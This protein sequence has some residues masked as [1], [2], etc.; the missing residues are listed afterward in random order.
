MSWARR[1]TKKLDLM[2][3]REHSDTNLL[4]LSIL[5]ISPLMQRLSHVK[6]VHGDRNLAYDVM[7]PEAVKIK[8]LEHQSLSSEFSIWDLGYGM[9]NQLDLVREFK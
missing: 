3:R 8:H 1:R 9:R 5:Q 7:F 4:F 2:R 6:T